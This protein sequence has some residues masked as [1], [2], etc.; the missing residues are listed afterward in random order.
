MALV[1]IED[2]TSAANAHKEAVV[3]I[4]L[5]T[6]FS[7]AAYVDGDEPKVIRD[8]DGQVL[9]PSVVSFTDENAVI[10]GWPA[11]ERGLLDPEHTVFSVKR[12]IGRGQDDLAKELGLLP[13]QVEDA[14]RKLVRIKIRENRLTPQEVS[15]EILKEVK[16]R[17]EKVLDRKVTKA[18]I[19]VPA[20]FDDTQRQA[21]RDAGRIAGLDVLRIINEPTAASLAYGLNSKKKGIVAVFDL[22]GGTFDISILRIAS[23]VFQ[24]LS[25]L[26]DTFLGGDDFDRALMDL[27]TEEMKVEHSEDTL[28]SPVVLQ[29]LKQAAEKTKIELTSADSATLSIQLSDPEISYEREVSRSEFN[30]LI[31]MLVEKTIEFCK[32]AINDARL[33]P[34][35]IEEVVMVGGSTRIP[36]VREKVEEFFG[37]PLHTGL[38]PDE[39]VAL[40]AAIQAQILS[41]GFREMMVLDVTPLSLGLET[42]GGA[43]SKLI[44]RNSPIPTRASEQFTT[45]V[46]DQTSVDIHVLQGEREMAEDCR[47]LGKW[48][49]TDIP[50]MP[51]NGPKITVT[52][53]LDANGLLK[54]DAKEDR[55]GKEL[56]IE[57]QPSSGLTD[58]E[59]ER[60]VKESIEHAMQDVENRQ[61]IDLRNEIDSIRRATI[62]A[63]EQSQSVCPAELLRTV[64]YALS[65]LL[66][67]EELEDIHELQKAIDDFN[68][69]SEPLAKLQMDAVAKTALQ[70]AES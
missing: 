19:T 57:V 10:V 56:S 55:S 65:D 31:V 51:A 52:F 33:T 47:S 4:D 49:L 67:A 42:F 18:V 37:R 63:L 38:N 59:V 39:V 23:G 5:G 27:A 48:K 44:M 30:D 45:F 21:T 9:V 40:G 2:L 15:A 3:G 6:T 12:L 60:M 28:R 25:T 16:T 35:R 14:E 34:D 61:R 58:E 17:A 64:N 68:E 62:K 41:G 50:P 70:E 11:R 46:D 43:M 54:V 69:A 53:T 20:Y 24:V 66:A 13:Y 29:A 32:T 26:G 22:G 8:E 36:L 7:L 1:T